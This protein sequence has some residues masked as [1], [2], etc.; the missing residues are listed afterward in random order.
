MKDFL[1]G[2]SALL[3]MAALA[4][5]IATHLKIFAIVFLGTGAIL[6]FVYGLCMV[7]FLGKGIRYAFTPEELRRN[8]K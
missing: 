2:A 1:I 4:V 8:F 3:L 6:C 7:A 5:V